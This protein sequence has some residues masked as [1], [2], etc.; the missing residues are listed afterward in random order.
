MDRPLPNAPIWT[1]EA[2]RKLNN[3]LFFVRAQ[4]R[5]RI[6]QIARDEELD[7]VTETLV[8]R[9]RQEFGQIG[10]AGAIASLNAPSKV[11]HPSH[12]KE[13]PD[14]RSGVWLNS[15]R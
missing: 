9:A 13:L 11:G 15:C 2:L 6:E 8:E 14:D 10:L 4:A 12:Y 7:R 1:A 3:I 5:F